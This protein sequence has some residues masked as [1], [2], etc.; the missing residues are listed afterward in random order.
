M[1][2]SMLATLWFFQTPESPTVTSIG[3]QIALAA[4]AQ[5]PAILTALAALTAAFIAIQNGRKTDKVDA[6]VDAV[7]ANAE[8]AATK[9]DEASLKVD[10]VH[11]ATQEIATKSEKIAAQT[12]GHLTRMTE[13]IKQLME[14]N[15][16]L[17][18]TVTTLVNIL[19][20]ERTAKAASTSKESVT[21]PAVRTE[22]LTQVI[23]T[24]TE[25][26]QASTEPPEEEQRKPEP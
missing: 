2:P 22:D 21:T 10:E 7:A 12:D 24:I 4:I 14:K 17:E 19:T 23:K 1:T 26:K 11:S 13:E 3:G 9:A 5:L 15:T 25:I 8:T 16:G 6:K 20:A 18:R